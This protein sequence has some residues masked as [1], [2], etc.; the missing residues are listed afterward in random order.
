MQ[1]SLKGF[2]D[3]LHSHR[4]ALAGFILAASLLSILL[5][6]YHFG[7]FDQ[8]VHIPFLKSD[9]DPGLYSG[10]PFIALKTEQPSFFWQMFKP[11]ADSRYFETI[12][13]FVHLLT[14]ILFFSSVWQLT[15]TIFQ[16]PLAAFFAV[17]GF[18][19]PHTGFVGFPVIEFSLLSRTFVLPFL[20]FALNCYLKEKYDSAFLLTGLMYNLNLLMV[21]FML[22]ATLVGIVVNWLKGKRGQW[23]APLF[24][25]AGA[26]PVLIKKWNA[27]IGFDLSIRS[28]WFSQISNGSLYQIFYLITDKPFILLTLGGIA[29]IGLFL[30]T[31]KHFQGSQM[32]RKLL[33][34]MWSW[35]ALTLSQIVITH[36]LPITFFIQ[37]QVSRAGIFILIVTYICF[38]GY[39]ASQWDKD[40]S[41]SPNLQFLAGCHWMSLTPIIPF[42]V[43]LIKD[44]LPQFLIARKI[45]LAT[46][47]LL[48]GINITI[49]SWLGFWQPGIHIRPKSTD[50]LDLLEWVRTNTEKGAVFITP[51]YMVGMYEPDWRVFSERSMVASLYDLFEIALTPDYFAEWKTRFDLLAPG[52]RVQFNGNFF[53]NRTIVREAYLSLSLSGF[54]RIHCEYEADYL[55]VEKPNQLVLETV[56]E[57]GSFSLLSL[58]DAFS[59]A[60]QSG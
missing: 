6:G 9:A 21:N 31:V 46:L 48:L 14:V 11:V 23:W 37:L 47:I 42:L 59:C 4:A 55:V 20:L 36:F 43:F 10:D 18:I 33:P 22:G 28:E 58:S 24:F 8:S 2:A 3:Y 51:P 45:M 29:A 52:A 50:W 30:V 13:F 57:N 35:I 16:S 7:S 49:M 40:K 26:A 54:E 56:Y 53:E 34:L 19:M 41:A 15:M 1:L 44:R 39:L 12:L 32:I 27:G 5:I 17:I 25:L 38:A 60:A